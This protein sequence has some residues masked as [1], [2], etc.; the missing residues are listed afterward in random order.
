MSN[1][2]VPVGGRGWSSLGSPVESL[3]SKLKPCSEAER[4]RAGAAEPRACPFNEREGGSGSAF[5]VA[6]RGT[7]IRFPSRRLAVG[8]K[9]VTGGNVRARDALAGSLRRHAAGDSSDRHRRT[10]SDRT[11]AGARQ[12]HP[13][14][15]ASRAAVGKGECLL[16]HR[17]CACGGPRR[18]PARDIPARDMEGSRL[19][20]ARAPA[21][22][23]G[24]NRSSRSS[25]LSPCALALLE[26]SYLFLQVGELLLISRGL[27]GIRP[28]A[29]NARLRCRVIGLG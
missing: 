10:P 28:L 14:F 27:R 25:S 23:S 6:R 2:A 12:L 5:G 15:D 4:W 18:N 16:D 24:G 19:E 26:R 17:N 11:A 22:G 9:A 20:V 1:V 21:R 8:L 7:S 3:T 13:R 29:V